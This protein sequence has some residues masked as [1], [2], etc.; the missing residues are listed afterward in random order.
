MRVYELAKEFDYKA[1]AFVDIIQSFGIEV[2]SHMSGLSEDQ[3]KVIREKMEMLD[4][5]KEGKEWASSPY[6]PEEAHSCHHTEEASEPTE[7]EGH[8]CHHTEEDS[9]SEEEVKVDEDELLQEVV[10]AVAK[11]FVEDNPP[12][13]EPEEVPEYEQA[14]VVEKPR[15]IWGWFKS[16]FG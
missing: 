16:F 5:T 1:T 10:E 3:A 8:S 9:G 7:E 11:S 15:G 2:N 13:S 12:P 4:H 14:V 6:P